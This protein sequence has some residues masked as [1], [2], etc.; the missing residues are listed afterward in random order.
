MNFLYNMMQHFR[1][2]QRMQRN[3]E[4]IEIVNRNAL[5]IVDYAEGPIEDWISRPE[6]CML[7]GGFTINRVRAL[8]QLAQYA[9]NENRPTVIFTQ[10]NRALQSMFFDHFG[11][12]CRIFNQ[13]V[14]TYE[15]FAGMTHNNIINMVSSMEPDSKGPPFDLLAY[16]DAVWHYAEARKLRFSLRLLAKLS[17]SKLLQC[18]MQDEA[19]GL[20][21]S[22]TADM[23]R[24][25]LLPIQHAESAITATICRLFSAMESLLIPQTAPAAGTSIT[26]AF[27]QGTSVVVINLP[28]HPQA[29]WAHALLLQDLSQAIQFTPLVVLD[30]VSIAGSL[31]LQ[32]LVK[33]SSCFNL[34]ISG[35]DTASML[36]NEELFRTYVGTVSLFLIGI[37]TNAHSAAF[38]SALFGNYNQRDVNTSETRSTHPYPQPGGLNIIPYRGTGHNES[39]STSVRQEARVRPDELMTMPQ[40]GLYVLGRYPGMQPGEIIRT[41]CTD[42]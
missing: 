27:Q 16:V 41:I 33:M 37:H 10:D 3:I 11:P 17:V 14:T 8:V 32:R 2:M 22:S 40:Q 13:D 28:T 4:E 1:T 31:P 30:E 15:P 36:G 42:N 18:V 23:L 6:S 5:G 21:S 12:R 7:S 19:Q 26:Q 25:F 24:N 39:Y 34:C 20:L 29:A 9:Q 38:I 35:K